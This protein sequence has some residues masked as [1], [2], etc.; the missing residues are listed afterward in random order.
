MLFCKRNAGKLLAAGLASVMA[1]GQAVPASALVGDTTGMVN[2]ILSPEPSP[3]PLP[4]LFQ[5]YGLYIDAG[6]VEHE[7][8]D[9][10]Y[11]AFIEDINF[12]ADGGLYAEMVKNRSFEYDRL[13]TNGAKHGWLDV[14]TVTTEVKKEGGLNA[15]NP[16]YMEITNAS[17][18]QGGIANYG[19]LDGMSIGKGMNYKFSVWAK[20]ADGYT[21]SLT[22]N[23]KAG[24]TVA[25]T[26]K[27]EAVTSEWKKYEL[28]L[29]SSVTAGAIIAGQE[30]QTEEVSLEVTVGKGAVDVDM[31]SLFPENTYKGR[32]NGLRADLAGLVADLTPKFLRFPGGCV[33]EGVS[34]D[35]AY[36]WK[37]SIGCDENGQPLE[38]NGTYG[39]VAARPQGQDIW[40]DEARA[41]EF[42]Y[43]MT[44]GLGFYEYFQFA[45]DMGA[46]GL[47]VLN[48][49]LCCQ[50]QSN[51]SG[52][53]VDSEEFKK[54]I[55]DAL[56]L[57][58]FCR[59]DES[60]TWGKV[61]IAMGH[62]EPFALKYI[63][64]GN[65]EWGTDF[66]EH[67]E[68]F[69]D[70]FAQKAKENPEMY[71]DIE[72]CFTAGVDD[73]DSGRAQYM[74]AYNRASSWLASHE[75]SEVKDYAGLIDHHYYNDPS[76]FFANN[77]YYDEENY[78]RTAEGMTE[79][80]FGGGI[81]VFL[82][83]YAGKSNTL[84]AALSE[85]SYM[86]GLERNGDIVKLAAYAPLFGNVTSNQWTP[87]LI[88]FNNSKAWGS[89]NY[90]VQKL[91]ANNA[92]TKLISSKLTDNHD[93]N[94]LSQVDLKGK[95]GLGTWNTSAEFD[96]FK[97][98]NNETGEVLA[99]QDFETDTL[100][101][102]EILEGDWAVKD[103]KL[104]QTAQNT[105][106]NNGTTAYFGNVDW[107][108]YTITVEA[109]KISG[110][111]GFLIP[112]AVDNAEH[113]LFWNFGGWNNTNSCI[114]EIIDGGRPVLKERA[115]G[116]Q[117]GHKY[118]LKVVVT[119]TG[120]KCYV[121][122]QLH[123]EYDTGIQTNDI[124]HVVS[125]DETGDMIVKLV[126]ASGTEKTIGTTLYNT[127]SVEPQADV[128][129]LSGTD[130]KGNNSA[131]EPEKYKI[132]QSKLDVSENF[133]MTVPGYSVTVVRIHVKAKESDGKAL[134]NINDEI[135]ESED[136][137]GLAAEEI[138]IGDELGSLQAATLYTGGT[139]K[140]TAKIAYG[141]PGTY[142]RVDALTGADNEIS[143]QFTSEDP[144]IAAVDKDGTI[145]AKKKGN[146]DIKV[147]VKAS[148]GSVM[149]Y[150]YQV[151]V[152]KASLKLKAKKTVTAGKKASV[153]AKI[154]GYKAADLQWSVDKKEIV[155]LS[156]NKGK[157]TVKVT[158]KKAGKAVITVKAG[159]LTAKMNVTVKAAKEKAK[160]T[161]KKAE[162]KK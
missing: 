1:F 16:Q 81:P 3:A 109:T 20:G 79:S 29:T 108:N 65:E 75:G 122:G 78:S 30:D 24:D 94:Q 44:Y 124:Y 55:Q 97:V 54:Y 87:D 92:G 67:Y 58:E 160:K 93:N 77:D 114:Q 21:G 159:K 83:E 63:G 135:T 66:F 7:I 31:V 104:V 99:M 103:G 110:S 6:N 112:F 111:E 147:L 2:G 138:A 41:T 42:P 80:K 49:G 96:N 142:Q 51:G 43:Y 40:A 106:L 71:G 143:L 86:T 68:A 33:I 64:I 19:F 11:G 137:K 28:T 25:A 150:L 39:D 154:A 45:E 129:Q 126:N 141:L 85:A 74:G 133:Y 121:D 98:T 5:D 38:F 140:K 57:V 36:D 89:V 50:G 101:Q 18:E 131:E 107:E 61:R 149:N 88:W 95:V 102:W 116:V 9:M 105:Q 37:D 12:A 91:F 152:K 155:S 153:T 62:K 15:N 134:E 148:D 156:P 130:I 69:V 60:T 161:A 120:V 46:V 10:L 56:D 76:W 70:A 158:A 52:Y 118:Q 157:K 73:G 144:S 82:G 23:L 35:A 146:T 127:E 26:G 22:A 115:G 119:G 53:S 128:Y 72:L 13:A 117:T 8:S 47:P 162:K 17:S 32:E 125:T 123:L 136:A 90:Y 100:S 27:I 113:S 34:L 145:T 14:G 48:C 139:A 84:L 4:E 132:E 59:G 151:T